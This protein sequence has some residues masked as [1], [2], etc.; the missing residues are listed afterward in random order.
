MGSD[1]SKAKRLAPGLRYQ[2]A[3][4]RN[5][6]HD[7]F[8]LIYQSYLHAGLVQN[9]DNGIRLTP[10]HLLDSTEVFVTKLEDTVVSTISL[11]GDGKLGLPLE[12]IYRHNVQII[13]RRGLKMA[14]IGSLADRRDSPVRFIETFAGMGRLL[15]QVAMSRGYDG[16]VA[17]THPKHARLYSRILP[18]EQIGCEATCPYANGNPAVM[19]ALVFDDHRGSELYERFFGSLSQTSDTTPKPWSTDTL[20]H[21]SRFLPKAVESETHAQP[22]PMLLR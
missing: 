2:I 18:F 13:R 19:L 10:Y 8:A 21:F 9:N 5:E 3:N 7:A 16:L 14:E 15:A 12:S 11:I 4:E 1:R 17:A 22:V 6:L 20:D